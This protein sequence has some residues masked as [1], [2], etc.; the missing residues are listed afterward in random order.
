MTDRTRCI[1]LNIPGN[2]SGVVLS[3]EELEDVANLAL[4]ADAYLLWD[5]TYAPAHL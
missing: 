3:P 5:D 4:E 2:P 1:I